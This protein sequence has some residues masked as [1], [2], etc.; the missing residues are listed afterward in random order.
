MPGAE[1]VLGG[2]GP[3]G[4]SPRERPP[5]GAT[6]ASGCPMTQALPSGSATNFVPSPDFTRNK[7]ACLPSFWASA[8]LLLTSDGVA[9][10]LPPTSRMTSPTLKPC[11]AATPPPATAVTTTPSPLEPETLLA[12][13]S[14]KPSFGISLSG[15]SR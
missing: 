4:P 2:D 13:A 6:D 7:T 14:V 15:T 1:L 8:R 9:T 11:S 3:Y 10:V 12:G 5:A